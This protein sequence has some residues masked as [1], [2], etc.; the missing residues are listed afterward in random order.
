M[1]LFGSWQDREKLIM[2]DLARVHLPG[3]YLIKVCFK[4]GSKIVVVVL[5]STYGFNKSSENF[6]HDGRMAK[7]PLYQQMT[8]KIK[9]IQI[10]KWMNEWMKIFVLHDVEK[11]TQ[12]RTKS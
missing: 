8:W 3:Q 12:Y 7:G 5:F 9:V 4:F 2:V 10:N 1:L 11:S 6:D